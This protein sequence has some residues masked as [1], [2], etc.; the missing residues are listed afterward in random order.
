MPASSRR[1]FLRISGAAG[2]G[3]ALAG[4]LPAFT[5]HA[6]PDRPTDV[7]LVPEDR[8]TTLWYR[9]PADE[10]R[11]I[12]EAL[13]VG[14]GR[15]GALVGCDPA[16]D[17]VYLTDGAFWSGGRNDTSTDDGQLPYGRDDFGSFGLLAKLRIT[18]PGHSGP[19]LRDYRRQLDLSNGVV[20]T[21]YTLRGVRH[22]RE[23]YASHPDDVVV[24][25]LTGGPH[26]GMVSLAG[27]HD[28]TTSG[29][30]GRLSFTGKLANGL[31]YAAAVTATAST[32]RIT[33][34]D[35]TLSFSDCREL[36]I[37]V[38]AG[39][40]YAPDADQDFRDPKSDPLAL[41]RHKVDA[42]A[43]VPGRRLLDTHVADYQKLYNRFSIDLGR[44]TPLQRSLDSWSRIAVR[45]TDRTTPDPELEAAYVQY[46]RYLTITGS[47]DWLPMNLQ[48]IWVH[49]NTPDWY[50]DYH[51]DINIQMNYWLADP[52]GLGENSLALA[53][54]CVSQL[55]VWTDVT[56]RLFNNERNRFR[57]TSGKVA[58]WAV[59]FS[60]NIH[61]GSGWAWHPSGNAWLCNSLWRHYE[62]S[63]DRAYLELIYPVLKG[64]AEFWQARLITTKVTD[65]DGTSRE[66]LIDDTAWSPEHGPDSKGITYAQELAWELFEEFT[67][68]AR[69]LDRDPELAADLADMQKRL[70]L[71]K[72]SPKTGWLE[73][74][75]SPENLGETTHRH[76]SPLIGFYPG[77]RITAD[78]SPAE[79][80][81]G[82]RALLT[83]RGTDTFGWGCAWRS[84][85]WSRLK[86]A[87]KAYQLYLNVLRP[88]VANS[89]G[90]S[91]NWFDM[92]SQGSYTI[93]QI[94][95]NLGGAAAAL[96]ML[97]Y[98]RPGVIELLPA[99]PDAWAEKGSLTGVGARGG[100]SVDFSWRDGKATSATVR[101]VGGTA[102]ELRAGTFRKQISLKPGKSVTVR[103]P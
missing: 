82:V 61:G 49:N 7:D 3:L 55:P 85:C 67:T 40:D 10:A 28:E 33:M 92:Y 91:A 95:A 96:E 35:D 73:E 48:G 64:A 98:S 97:L 16:D 103:I 20:S 60:T 47:R 21:T 58:G 31:R 75:M 65:T 8:A 87:D 76:L 22:R 38:C 44:S 62:Y 100:F 93:F 90:T 71:P 11:I 57:N 68:A 30:N 102:T 89:N 72:V 81:D 23:V 2:G 4:G 9:T 45:Y 29:G 84:L 25:R 56:K 12:Q 43:R 88:S 5:A 94:D 34:D 42:A 39:T 69:V 79:L 24:I 70:Y 86:D 41:A 32:G 6:A 17:F 15:L 53:R 83:A 46:G 14:N 37:V 99:L 1:D 19:E 36:L 63:Q 18:L 27:T 50:A 66:V 101:S 13:P 51:T 26:T 77:D 54:Y 78:R 52:A 59:A 74:W 80:I